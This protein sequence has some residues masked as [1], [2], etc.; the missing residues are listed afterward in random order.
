MRLTKS[1][2]IASGTKITLHFL[3]TCVHTNGHVLPKNFMFLSPV[4]ISNDSWPI[5]IFGNFKTK[6]RR[7][8]KLAD[9]SVI[10]L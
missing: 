7:W 10:K 1:H 5:S 2:S 9:F 8:V 4:Q 6:Q 3:N